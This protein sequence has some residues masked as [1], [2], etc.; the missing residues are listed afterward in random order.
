MEEKRLA[1][2]RAHIVLGRLPEKKIRIVIIIIIIIAAHT[3]EP[4]EVGGGL[5]VLSV[6]CRVKSSRWRFRV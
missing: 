6:P 1:C 2:E 3:R 4:L 5:P